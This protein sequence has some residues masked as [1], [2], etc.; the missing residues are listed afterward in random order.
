M[1]R[2]KNAKELN[3]ED[4]LWDFK[5][6][7]RS[8]KV[9]S[10]K[11]NAIS[12]DS[13]T[14]NRPKRTVSKVASQRL[15]SQ[16]DNSDS[17]SDCLI[18][19]S[20]GHDPELR[21]SRK[22]AFLTSSGPNDDLMSK[23]SLAMQT[24]LGVDESDSSQTLQALKSPQ[25]Q[26]TTNVKTK[27][28]AIKT[29]V[30][31]KTKDVNKIGK[32]KTGRRSEAKTDEKTNQSSGGY[33][34]FCQ[35]PFSALLRLSPNAHTMECMDLPFLSDTEECEDGVCC[36]SRLPSHYRKYT[37][38]QLA[39]SRDTTQN[40]KSADLTVDEDVK[41]HISNTNDMPKSTSSQKSAA[42]TSSSSKATSKSTSQANSIIDSLESEEM[43][44]PVHKGV[45]LTMMGK[46]AKK[47]IME[48]I[49][50]KSAAVSSK[51]DNDEVGGFFVAHDRDDE[52]E[53][54]LTELLAGSE[55]EEER[56]DVDEDNAEIHCDQ[57]EHVEIDKDQYE[58]DNTGNE[59]GNMG[60]YDDCDARVGDDM[61][62]CDKNDKRNDDEKLSINDVT[63]DD[64]LTTDPS[65]SL[66]KVPVSSLARKQTSIF[67]FFSRPSIKAYK[68]EAAKT[69]QA[70][71]TCDIKELR[72]GLAR[73]ASTPLL[74]DPSPRGG[75]DLKRSKT[76]GA[77]IS[78]DEKT[79]YNKGA[80]RNCPFY[81]RI[82]GTTLTVDAFRYGVIPGCRAYVLTHFHY[83]HYGGLTK[84]F[85]Q[86]LYCS[87][88]TGNLVRT[89]IKVDPQYIHTL[90]LNQPCDVEGVE[91]T[92]MEANH[93]PGAVIILLR[94]KSGQTFLHTGD[95]RADP[96]MEQ[97]PPLVGTKIHQLYLD[98]TYCDPSYTF[99]PQSEVIKFAVT[100]TKKHVEA[101][102]NTLVVCG[103][104]TIG[105]ERV[106][107]AIADALESKVCVKKDKK[108]ILD[109]LEDQHL[110]KM[111]T[112]CPT[113]ARVHVLPMGKLKPNEL[114]IY[115]SQHTKFNSILA[116]EPTGWSH[117]NRVVSLEQIKPKYSRNGITIYGI[118]YSEHSSY[119]E[120]K[121]F[122]QYIRP[123]RILATVN[124][125]N[126]Q[127]RQKMNTLFMTWLSEV[128]KHDPA[129]KEPVPTEKQSFLSSWFK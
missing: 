35:V 8:K 107:T 118:P 27:R 56:G 41:L 55:D 62:I 117:S 33:C 109:C 111:V 65:L 122:T 21:E 64:K 70:D 75:F 103:T 89:K 123:D 46:T 73:I 91:L 119:L 19:S 40:R 93:C 25:T 44:E 2:S 37:H 76:V 52:S 72:N 4:D 6:L 129:K 31:A 59:I 28:S 23:S 16:I 84:H 106:F 14:N 48:T 50:G 128:K 30:I 18:V 87:K 12:A 17:D 47:N 61:E 7:K 88:V 95:F 15:K 100:L 113:E 86:H 49:P 13:R 121:R 125:T 60:N 58:T 11:N 80:G 90:P 79:V 112:L 51:T 10:K 26:K 105:K 9:P 102:P 74:G 68:T 63:S 43:E 34:P 85:K 114:S 94:L 42:S 67:S 57:N 69:N 53:K 20:H 92:L 108:V 97:Y 38:T 104:Y 78:G 126:P 99:P 110:Q 71:R 29:K 101:S 98:T 124:N 5:S 54:E 83:D 36:L 45:G 81:K 127:S 66:G 22:R 32:K 115:L 77:G 39:G 3:E 96:A 82:P 120:M 1:K 24:Q 116:L